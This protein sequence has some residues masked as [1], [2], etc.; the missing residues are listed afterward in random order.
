MLRTDLCM[1][2]GQRLPSSSK[3]NRAGNAAKS[4]DWFLEHL[5]FHRSKMV[6]LPLQYNIGQS[7]Y[8]HFPLLLK[9]IYPLVT[10]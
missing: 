4:S 8:N 10:V 7:L 9:L 6:I 1:C 5:G 2:G 3:K